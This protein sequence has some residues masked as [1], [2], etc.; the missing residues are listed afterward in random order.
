MNFVAFLA[1][2]L[3]VIGLWMTSSKHHRS[4]NWGYGLGAIG[5]LFW[6]IVAISVNS[7]WLALANFVIGIVNLRGFFR[8]RRFVG[9]DE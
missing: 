7:F 2:V 9:D 5:C 6:M 1:C 3:T 8:T 4:R